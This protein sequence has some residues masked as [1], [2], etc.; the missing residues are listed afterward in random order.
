MTVYKTYGS[1]TISIVPF[2]SGMPYL[3]TANLDV[4]K[5]VIAGGVK[6]GFYKAE[7]LS[8]SLLCVAILIFSP[9]VL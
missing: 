9:L 3:M 1:D 8:R 2:V 7:R 4:A 5:Q 6:S